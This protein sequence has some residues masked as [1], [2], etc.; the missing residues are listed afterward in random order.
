MVPHLRPARE[1]SLERSRNSTPRLDKSASV[2]TSSPTAVLCTPHRLSIDTPIRSAEAN[3][4]T[5]LKVSSHTATDFGGIM[6]VWHVRYIVPE[7]LIGLT[8]FSLTTARLLLYLS[9]SGP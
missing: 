6:C 2:H 9:R 1:S 3:W 5:A 8:G 7:V 4:R